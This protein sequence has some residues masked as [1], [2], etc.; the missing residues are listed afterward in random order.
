MIP[1]VRRLIK[2]LCANF[3][4]TGSTEVKNGAEDSRRFYR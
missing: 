2:E 4:E 3:S 1:E